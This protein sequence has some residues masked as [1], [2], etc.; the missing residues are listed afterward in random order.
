M[1]A[2]PDS[3]NMAAAITIENPHQDEVTIA[4]SKVD[5]CARR[6][7][8]LGPERERLEQ[9]L[10]RAKADVAAAEGYL[11]TNQ[12]AGADRQA[13]LDKAQAELRTITAA[14]PELATE[15]AD[16]REQD[17]NQRRKELTDALAALEGN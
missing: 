15:V 13:D 16:R 8:E 12:D 5:V 4:W 9:K 3:A 10:D 14:H 2:T 7:A 6:L 1:P 17:R 11:S